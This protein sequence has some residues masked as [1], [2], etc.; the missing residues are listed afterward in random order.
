[1]HSVRFSLKNAEI[2][3]TRLKGDTMD[4]KDLTALDAP[5][6]QCGTKTMASSG[7]SE[8]LRK[9]DQ[10][11][12]LVASVALG[13]VIAWAA[14]LGCEELVQTKCVGPSVVD[15]VRTTDQPQETTLET[16]YRSVATL[17]P[18]PSSPL[19]LNSQSNPIDTQ[20]NTSQ[21]SP[22]PEEKLSEPKSAF[23][24]HRTSTH[25]KV[26]D[27]KIGLLMLWHGSLSRTRPKARS[28][29]ESWR[30]NDHHWR[31]ND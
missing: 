13:L 8:V 21:C 9:F 14:V 17:A 11:T 23:P 12:T 29:K 30:F 2:S 25:H 24:R 31:A 5:R 3:P 28:W 6:L 27:V 4:G 20:I 7:K 16:S 22:E 1:M 19:A 18:N 26:A 15:T 10:N